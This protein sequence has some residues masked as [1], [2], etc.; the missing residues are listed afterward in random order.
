[1]RYITAAGGAI[2]MFVGILLVCII[3]GAFLLPTFQDPVTV[4]FGL[5]YISATPSLLVG[6]VLGIVGSIHSYR[7][8]LKRY[9]RKSAPNSNTHSKS[10]D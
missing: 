8:T 9:E 2:F 6:T 4:P 3:I 1:M 7:S 10:V 5:F